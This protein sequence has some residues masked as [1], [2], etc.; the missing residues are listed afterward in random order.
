[1][2]I[3]RLTCMSTLLI[4]LTHF[5]GAST[6]FQPLLALLWAF[7]ILT[8]KFHHKFHCTLSFLNCRTCTSL[9]ILI[10]LFT[11]HVKYSAQVLLITQLHKIHLSHTEILSYRKRHTLVS[12]HL[13]NYTG[14]IAWFHGI[15]KEL[16]P[17]VQFLPQGYNIL[18]IKLRFSN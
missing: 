5:S 9:C 7:F 6:W 10:K 1:M 3:C 8:C 11:D 13:Y 15:L 12:H 18:F 17:S 14:L 16:E 4:R 2:G